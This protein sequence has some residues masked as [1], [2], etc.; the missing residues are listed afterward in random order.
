MLPPSLL[1]KAPMLSPTSSPFVPAAQNTTAF[2]PVNALRRVSGLVASP[3]IHSALSPLNWALTMMSANHVGICITPG[4]S[5][6]AIAITG[7]PSDSSRSI[8]AL[9]VFP[10]APTTTVGHSG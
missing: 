2:A 7:S 1:S 8:T 5:S 10:L 6:R 4:L 3:C 9:A